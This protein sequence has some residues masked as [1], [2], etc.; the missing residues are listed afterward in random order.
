MLSGVYL[1]VFLFLFFCFCVLL[2]SSVCDRLLRGRSVEGGV[3][4]YLGG[5][6]VGRGSGHCHTLDRVDAVQVGRANRMLSVGLK[7]H[8]TFKQP[9]W[10]HFSLLSNLS[11][12][13]RM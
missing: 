8:I 9:Q 1:A 12:L 3:L 6:T 4:P 7:N 10:L 2:F 13:H 11:R 5:H